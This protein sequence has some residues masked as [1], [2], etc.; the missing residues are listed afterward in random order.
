[1]AKKQ[2]KEKTL[3]TWTRYAA[4]GMALSALL[5]VTGCSS[6]EKSALDPKKP[7]NISVWTYYTGAQQEEFNALVDT[8]NKTEGQK[9]GITVEAYSEGNVGDLTDAVIASA[10]KKVG[11]KDM[12]NIFAAYSDTAYQL[13]EMGLLKDISSY[14]SDEEKD[15]YITSYLDEGDLNGNGELK[16]FPIAKATEIFMIN[17][18]DWDKFA[19]ATGA[20]M[21]DLSTIE[22]V[23]QVAADYYA[24]TDSLTD[25]PDDGKAF[26]GRDAVA[27]YMIIGAKQLGVDLISIGKDG[28]VQINFP[29]DVAKK[30]WD[31]Y[32]VPFINGYF[33]A[34]GRFRSDDVKTGNAICFVGSSASTSFFPTE[35]ILSDEEKYPIEV[36]VLQAPRFAD[37][38]DYA[39]QQGA[40]MAVTE[41]TDAQIEASVAF[42]KW[43]TGE[44]NNIRFSI[45]SGYMPVKKAA[46]SM[47]KIEKIEELS[48]EVKESLQVS[49]DTV[50]SC[51]MYTIKGKDSSARSILESRICDAAAADRIKV[52]ELIARGM[53][54]EDAVALYDTDQ[55]FRQ[56]YTSTKA[57]LEGNSP[58]GD[59]AQSE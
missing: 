45:A 46:N 7:V 14:F 22:G 2:E 32:Y 38:E 19:E 52:E 17:Q 20:S 5:V 51:E 50:N 36:G 12:P 59:E 53:T 25:E 29:E 31:N 30:L 54:R 13:D 56:W 16:L 43:F 35:V 1:M 24:W 47:E 11:A 8:F 27:N 40:G 37:G 55:Q 28:Q 10:Q 15:E 21:D 34:M 23:T 57:M 48:R 6:K 39:V 42:L 33:S 9:R 49:L 58:A 3:N 41:G 26:F 18:T 44:E 4:A